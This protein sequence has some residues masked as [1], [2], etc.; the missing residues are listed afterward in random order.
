[1]SDYKHF[2][3]WDLSTLYHCVGLDFKGAATE[4]KNR[5]LL[6][7]DGPL[8]TGSIPG[9]YKLGIHTGQASFPKTE[10]RGR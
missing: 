4:A 8:F 7:Y 9:L 6:N 10:L 3:M 2:W 5:G 1:M